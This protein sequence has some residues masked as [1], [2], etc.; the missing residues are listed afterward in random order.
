MQTSGMAQQFSDGTKKTIT[1]AAP[2]RFA[3]PP[4][5]KAPAKPKAKK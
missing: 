3:P 1:T 4:M 5:R 2:K